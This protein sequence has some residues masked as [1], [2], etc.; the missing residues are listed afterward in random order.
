MWWK[1]S[2]MIFKSGLSTDQ[3]RD[4]LNQEVRFQLICINLA[5]LNVE[6][7]SMEAIDVKKYGKLFF[8]IVRKGNER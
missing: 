3:G 6:V 2:E 4:S 1:I 5:S 7:S 8:A